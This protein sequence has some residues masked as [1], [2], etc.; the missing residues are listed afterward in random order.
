MKQHHR[1]VASLLLLLAITASSDGQ[2]VDDA[3]IELASKESLLLMPE[4][5]LDYSVSK[6]PLIV[7]DKLWGFQVQVMKEDAISKVLVK[8]EARDLSD[9]PRRVAACKAYV[10]SFATE[11][12]Q[13]GFKLTSSKLPDIEKSDFKS[14]IVVELKFADNEGTIIVARK[15]MFFT[16]KGYDVTILA[17][18]NDDLKLLTEWASQIRP[19]AAQPSP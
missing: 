1:I 6:Q 15:R 11:L 17:T 14:P 7:A 12:S 16:T 18:D 13:A 5:P 19:A 4:P 2:S 8:V 10:N 3:A 9:R